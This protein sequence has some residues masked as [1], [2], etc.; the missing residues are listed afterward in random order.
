[1][2]YICGCRAIP[3]VMRKI[4]LCCNIHKELLEFEVKPMGINPC[5]EIK[6]KEVIRTPLQK[7]LDN[8]W[9][10]KG[11]LAEG[12]CYGVSFERFDQD[13]RF[14]ANRIGIEPFLIPETRNSETYIEYMQKYF[15][16]SKDIA[17]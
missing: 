7:I 3:N 13:G 2:F 11:D 12:L 9:F 16:L 4:S 10:I 5:N 8:W 1:M 17:T 14:F 6:Y 15:T